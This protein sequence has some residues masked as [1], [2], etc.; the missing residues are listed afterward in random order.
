LRS[1]LL[2][3]GFEE[4]LARR[5]LRGWVM[6]GKEMLSGKKS[7]KQKREA[8]IVLLPKAQSIHP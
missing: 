1:I 3:A 8:F 2:L 7:H 6:E 5:D 4:R